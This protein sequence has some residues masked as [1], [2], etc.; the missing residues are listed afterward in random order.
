[1]LAKTLFRTSSF[2]LTLLYAA[3]F[4]VSF[5]VL[6]G[7]I[8]WSSVAFMESQI[9]T[10]VA[11]EIAELEAWTNGADQAQLTAMVDSVTVRSPGVFYLLQDSA[12]RRLAGNLP[13]IAPKLGIYQVRRPDL[14]DEDRAKVLRGEGVRLAG[15]IYLFVGL[16]TYE[17]HEMKDMIERNFLLGLTITVLVAL[18]GGSLMS[19][20]VLGRVEAL[21]QASRAI[22][23]GDLK[24][25]IPLRG[26]DDEFDHLATSLNK[27]L[28]RIEALMEGLRQ[29]S[30]D[31]AH[32]LRTPLTRLRQRVEL[33][34]RKNN[35]SE[36]LR[37][38]L[39]HTLGDVDAIL[40][41]FGALL[42]ISQV[43]STG[44][45]ADFSDANL[46]E[47]LKTVV[48]VYLPAADEKGQTLLEVIPPGLNVQGDRGLLLQLFA[49][50]VENSVRHAPPG[51]RIEVAATRRGD[52]IEVAVA[53]NGPG[54][55]P[56]MRSRVFRRFVRLD[57]SRST[58][59]HGL[60]LSLA[61]AI[62]A[63]HRSTIE[64]ADNAPGLRAIVM[65][66]AAYPT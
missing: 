38:A 36:S 56:E 21:S 65:L 30:S 53:D 55:P 6:F 3:I 40:E 22:V 45:L 50:L 18:I 17:M 1:V 25:R 15:G 60:G 44:Q 54:I 5:A 61:A 24:R 43:E 47:I 62:A 35:D 32:D 13:A 8:Y 26:S 16:S 7:L 2:R 14:P 64:L 58:P 41:T 28:D 20:S 66:M 51:A 10:T 4:C 11:R 9:D 33:A 48:E 52:H 27:M 34:L 57:K 42:R 29:V 63:L 23:E 59:G 46:T 49:N 37:A 39:E 12:G 31:I 19:L